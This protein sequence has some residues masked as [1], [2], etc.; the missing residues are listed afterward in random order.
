MKKQKSYNSQNKKYKNLLI[1]KLI[2]TFI[3]KDLSCVYFYTIPVYF[4][5]KNEY[6]YMY[7]PMIHQY[8]SS[9]NTR[10]VMPEY[11]LIETR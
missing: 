4:F 9:I 10:S 8:T 5:G 3:K 2:H 1:Y 7:N 6:I 11:T